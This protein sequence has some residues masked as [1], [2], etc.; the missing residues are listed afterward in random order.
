MAFADLAEVLEEL[1]FGDRWTELCEKAQQHGRLYRPKT[2]EPRAR[3]VRWPREQIELP[4]PPGDPL[5]RKTCGRCA[6]TLPIRAFAV[7]PTENEA[8][9]PLAARREGWCRDCIGQWKSGW[10]ARRASDRYARRN[11]RG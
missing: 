6:L 8:P 11:E 2:R 1:G 3:P 4:L 5:A 9:E 10:A 7:L